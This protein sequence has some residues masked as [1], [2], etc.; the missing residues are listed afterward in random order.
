MSRHTKFW[1]NG[2]PTMPS[3]SDEKCSDTIY[4]YCNTNVVFMA[5]VSKDDVNV[6]ANKKICMMR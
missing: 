4:T 5:S 1:R 2:S 6:K 3:L